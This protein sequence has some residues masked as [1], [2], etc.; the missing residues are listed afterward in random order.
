[1]EKTTKI[2]LVIAIIL[3]IGTSAGTYAIYRASTT[4]TATLSTAAFQVK[5]NQSELKDKD[6]VH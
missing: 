6:W 5:T 1:M 4:G 3:L 2:L